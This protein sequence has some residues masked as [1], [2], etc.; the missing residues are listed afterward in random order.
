MNTSSK[1]ALLIIDVQ[2]FY[3]PGGSRS[4]VG[5]VEASLNARKIL[6]R[7]REVGWP[8]IYVRHNFEPGGD[9][10]EHVKPLEDEKV[11]SK[12]QVNSFKDTD[13]LDHLHKHQIQKL[14]ICGMM[15]HMCVEAATR[16]GHDY[17]FDC[18]VI[19]DACATKALQFSGQEISA[20]SVH[21][22]TLATLSGIYAKVLDTESFLEEVL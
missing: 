17:G 11:I 18:S 1:Q 8:V 5:P 20:E 6:N 16:A 13:L 14:V 22:T 3:F 12:N 7:F 4:L 21:Y 9:I 2:N 10:H 19:Q 15:T